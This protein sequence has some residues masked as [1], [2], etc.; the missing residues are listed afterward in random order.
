MVSIL[1]LDRAR[2]QAERLAEQAAGHLE[3][4]GEKADLLRALAR[5]T[6]TTEE[7][8]EGKATFCEQKVAKKLCSLGPCSVGAAGPDQRS[9]CA[10]FLKS[11]YFSFTRSCS[12][13]CPNN[14][15]M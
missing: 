4:F 7:L 3:S 15:L 13:T 2:A 6:V 12:R 11:G 14:A 10:A 1:G 9:F 5:F 8:K